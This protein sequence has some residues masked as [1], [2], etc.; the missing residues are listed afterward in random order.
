MSFRQ[1]GNTESHFIPP[2]SECSPDPFAMSYS[3]LSVKSLFSF[4]RHI[5]EMNVSGIVIFQI[6][7]ELSCRR[8]SSLIGQDES[9]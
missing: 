5:T 7:T 1:N 2:I 8:E 9:R 3:S 6:G 4:G